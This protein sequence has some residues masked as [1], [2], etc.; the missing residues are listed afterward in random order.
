MERI[1]LFSRSTV[2]PRNSTRIDTARQ[3]AEAL[4]KPKPLPKAL[5]ANETANKMAHQ[6][7]VLSISAL[8]P[9]SADAYAAR[10]YAVLHE[11]DAAGF[12]SIVAARIPESPD[13]TAIRDRLT[14]AS[15][16]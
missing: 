12:D 10:L 14:R 2:Q 8:M 3:R 6:P 7:R 4:F 15:T 9:A 5:C 13:W 16:A 11:L 1:S